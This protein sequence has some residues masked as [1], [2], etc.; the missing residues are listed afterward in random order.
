[1]KTTHRADARRLTS[2]A[3]L[4][5]SLLFASAAGAQEPPAPDAPCGSNADCGSFEGCLDGFC[6]ALMP[7]DMSCVADTDCP[8]AGSVCVDAM[9]WAPDGGGTGVEPQP[10]QVCEQDADCPNADLCIDGYCSSG[11][12][13]PDAG[14]CAEDADCGEGEMCVACF[15]MPTEGTCRADADCPDGQVCDLVSVGSAGGSSGGD[16]IP[17]PVC[18]GEY[19]FCSVDFTQ[20][21]PDP[22]CDAFCELATSCGGD[23]SVS[24]DD[25]ASGESSG[26]AGTESAE[27][28]QSADAAECIGFCSYLLTDPEAAAEMEAFLTCVDANAVAGCDAIAD[29]CGGE[30]EALGEAARDVPAGA[31]AVDDDGTGGATGGGAEAESASVGDLFGNAFGDDSAN[32]DGADGGVGDGEAA[33]DGAGTEDDTG[34]TIGHAP[35][36]GVAGL[37]LLALAGLRIGRRRR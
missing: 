31:V 33:A 24:S 7:T 35:T 1:M 10:A 34:C 21:T 18:E 25:G 17:A 13:P 9:C 29:A 15:C 19:G 28:P 30:A 8:D 3:A 32:G 14:D 37:F 26:G 12:P 36:P 23:T 27:Q 20:V 6:T 16:D 2:A 22:R 11:D 4:L 5:T